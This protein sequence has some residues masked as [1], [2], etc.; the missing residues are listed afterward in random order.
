[1]RA[2]LVRLV[3]LALLVT[4]CATA[5]APPPTAL[6]A[7]ERASAYEDAARGRATFELSCPKEQIQTTPLGEWASA[8]LMTADRVV[9]VTGC[10][11]KLVYV[12]RC[13]WSSPDGVSIAGKSCVAFLDSDEHKGAATASDAGR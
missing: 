12:A 13:T 1:M 6:S 3:C 2:I 5:S 7:A 8:G 10:G 11:R 9:G 4:G